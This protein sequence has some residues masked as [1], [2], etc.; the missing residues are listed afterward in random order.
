MKNKPII[1]LI[2][3][4]IA[5]IAS[6]QTVQAQC[7]MCKA[8]AESNIENHSNNVGQSLNTGILYLMTIPYIIIGSIFFFSFK[9]QILSFFKGLS[10]NK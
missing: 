2:L 10:L 5:F 4:C 9:K 6:E 7:A 3:I 1:T 8:V